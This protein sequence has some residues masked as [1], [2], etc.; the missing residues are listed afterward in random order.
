MGRSKEDPNDDESVYELLILAGGKGNQS[1]NGGW[2]DQSLLFGC[3]GWCVCERER[4]LTRCD[5]GKEWW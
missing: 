5:V 3:G 4:E 1:I 2:M